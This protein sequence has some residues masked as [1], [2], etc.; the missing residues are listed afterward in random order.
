MGNASGEAVTTNFYQTT[1]G[2]WLPKF[3][4]EHLTEESP[5]EQVRAIDGKTG[6]PIPDL[7]YYIKAPDGTTYSGYTDTNGL[8][9]RVATYHPE[10]LSV[11]FGEDAET[12]MR[13]G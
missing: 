2:D 3:G 10:E 7:A 12:K 6:E 1:Q 11:W 13:E 5:D 4:P 9:E 8:C